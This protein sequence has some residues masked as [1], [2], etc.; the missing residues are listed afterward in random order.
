VAGHPYHQRDPP[1]RP[2]IHPPATPKPCG[3]PVPQPPTLVHTSVHHSKLLCI[4]AAH[5]SRLKAEGNHSTRCQPRRSSLAPAHK[6][7]MSMK[8][9][10]VSST[11]RRRTSAAISSCLSIH[12]MNTAPQLSMLCWLTFRYQDLHKPDSTDHFGKPW[13][14]LSSSGTP[15]PFSTYEQQPSGSLTSRGTIAASVGT[16]EWPGPDAFSTPPWDLSI[17]HHQASHT[18][19]QPTRHV[20]LAE[21]N[22][23][24]PH[25]PTHVSVGLTPPGLKHP[26]AHIAVDMCPAMHAN[27]TNISCLAPSHHVTSHLVA[28]NVTHTRYPYH[29]RR[30]HLVSHAES[31]SR[32][33]ASASTAPP[34][35]DGCPLCRKRHPVGQG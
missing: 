22:Q 11:V 14:S 32:S 4:A 30:C 23:I 7:S 27:L 1:I 21:Q 12:S 24:S 20:L 31:I 6:E 29:M 26:G 28:M 17:L 25:T 2:H 8:W 34:D 16:S 33:L 9:G 10:P 35:M 5:Q 19:S 18:L 15:F 3:P 13:R